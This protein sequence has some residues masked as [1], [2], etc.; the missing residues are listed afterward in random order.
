[1]SDH[2]CRHLH[3]CIVNTTVHFSHRICLVVV[4]HLVCKVLSFVQLIFPVSSDTEH[5][6]SD[7]YKS[8]WSKSVGSFRTTAPRCRRWMSFIRNAEDLWIFSCSQDNFSSREGWKLSCLWTGRVVVVAAFALVSLLMSMTWWFLPCSFSPDKKVFWV[9]CGVFL[10]KFFLHI[11][12][13][14]IRHMQDIFDYALLTHLETFEQLL[15]LRF[16]RNNAN[17]LFGNSRPTA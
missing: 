17:V 10:S 13:L 8:L 12:L 4:V 14:R 9:S 2:R 5:L 3:L 11:K 1:M 15:N 7:L 16:R 6:H